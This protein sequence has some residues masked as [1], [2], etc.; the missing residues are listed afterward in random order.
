MAELTILVPSARV[1]ALRESLL[2]SYTTIADALHH[3]INAAIDDEGDVADAFGHHVELDDIHAALDQLPE[4]A[5]E[6]VELTAHPEVLSD[7]VYDALTSA[8]EQF[9]VACEHYQR[10]QASHETASA[11]LAAV[12]DLYR[13]LRE[14]QDGPIR[15]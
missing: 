13:L 12:E 5:D 6:D 1:A 11:A 8:T 15:R 10:G 3:A 9:S 14:I 2:H 4:R 7:A